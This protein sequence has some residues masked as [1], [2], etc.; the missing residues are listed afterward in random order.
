MTECVT[1]PVKRKSL[2]MTVTSEE[3]RKANW[4]L[5]ARGRLE[6]LNAEN[7]ALQEKY[8]K[9][10]KFINERIEYKRLNTHERGRMCRQRQAMLQYKDALTE[11]IKA[12]DIEIDKATS[13]TTPPPPISSQDAYNAARIAINSELSY[14]GLSQGNSKRHEGQPE[15]TPGEFLLCMEKCLKDGMDA[16]YK[17]DGG[18]TC[19]DFVR[20]VTALGTR[21]MALHGAP[22]REGFTHM[23]VPAYTKYL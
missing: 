18:K 11:R 6:R 13:K 9:L 4:L 22:Q 3:I 14:Q 21:C 12:L 8:D 19:L 10:N 16:W 17:P 7:D 20:K 1:T 23:E 5:G 15:M 2:N